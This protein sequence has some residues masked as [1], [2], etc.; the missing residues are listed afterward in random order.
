MGPRFACLFALVGIG[1]A[2]GARDAQAQLFG[3]EA[4]N[5][6][7]PAAGGM[8]GTSIA[9]PQDVTSAI[10]G[11]PASL[12]QFEGTQF[13]I[14]VTWAEPTYH[15]TQTEAIGG[16]VEPFSAKSSGLGLI[17]GNIGVAQDFSALGLPAT[18]GFGLVTTSGGSIDFRQVRASHGA[19]AELV[20]VNLPATVGVDLTDRLSAGGSLSVGVAL[21]DPPFFGAMSTAY[22]LR[23]SAGLDYKLTGSTTL[24]AYYQTKQLFRFSDAIVLEDDPLPDNSYDVKMGMPPNIGLGIAN[25]SLA[26]GRL[27]LAVDVLYKMWNEADLFQGFYDNQWVVQLGG[28]YSLGRYRLRAGYA[29]AQNPLDPTPDEVI[30]GF[31]LPGTLPFVQFNQGLVAFTSQH[32]IAG[33]V[34]VRDLLPGVDLDVMAGGMFLDSARISASTSTSVSSYWIGAGLTWRFRRGSCERLPVADQW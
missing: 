6:L 33:G 22:G 31:E 21:F 1:M 18:F 7:M 16:L 8:A 11:N 19:N 32:R 9:E 34:G 13:L 2:W 5:T 10:N 14:G 17:G 30:G 23:G 4:N 24:G 25:R 27:L 20:I 15:L 26:D 29:W 3:V 12:T 28:Q